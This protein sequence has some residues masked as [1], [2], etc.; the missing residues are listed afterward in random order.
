[1]KVTF[2]S[3]VRN[4][5]NEQQLQWIKLSGQ[6]LGTAF[7]YSPQ[8]REMQSV[9]SFFQNENWVNEWGFFSCPENRK[10]FPVLQKLSF[11]DTLAEEYQALFIGPN[12][13]EAPPWGSVYLDPE[14]VIFGETTLALE[15][16]LRQHQ[17]AFQQNEAVDHIGLMLWL[18]SFLSE[19]NPSLLKEFL[20]QHLF[21]WV[22]QYLERLKSQKVSV[23]YA[24]LAVLCEIMLKDWQKML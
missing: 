22:W 21:T 14:E 5:M 11:S 8:A 10:N 12:H 4:Q 20:E 23:F 6:L 17:I 1:M 13:L 19:E 15:N 16:F 3:F 18:A 2:F 24:Q 7:Y 9:L